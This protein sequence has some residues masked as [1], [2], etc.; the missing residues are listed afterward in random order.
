MSLPTYGRHI[1]KG[2]SAADIV[3]NKS[4]LS[5]DGREPSSATESAISGHRVCTSA[6]AIHIPCEDTTVV[7]LGLA[8]SRFEYIAHIANKDLY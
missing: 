2:N 1:R 6:G 8:L 5:A 3:G 7:A 4:I